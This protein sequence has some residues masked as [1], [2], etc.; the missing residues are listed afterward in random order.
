MVIKSLQN[1]L[2]IDRRNAF[3]VILQ[4]LHFKFPEKHAWTP[5]DKLAPSALVELA[6]RAS[7]P[8]F[9]HQSKI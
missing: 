9:L 4:N 2:R 6:L 1:F 8:G 5:L 3:P 7:F